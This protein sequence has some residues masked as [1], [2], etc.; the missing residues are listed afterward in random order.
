MEQNT[1]NLITEILANQNIRTHELTSALKLLTILFYFFL[2]IISA[3]LLRNFNIFA[4]IITTVIAIIFN[5][6]LTVS[7]YTQ[8]KIGKILIDALSKLAKEGQAPLFKEN[9]IAKGI[10]PG[11][12]LSI[13][14][15][16]Q[17]KVFL[18]LLF[19]IGII[20]PIYLYIFADW[21]KS[22]S[23]EL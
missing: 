22:N 2:V 14:D 13:I 19:L 7:I 8:I 5:L 10:Q 21:K 16:I 4:R 9:L 1:I 12:K 20:T 15:P 11:S 17:L 6:I 23:N 18:F 3:Y